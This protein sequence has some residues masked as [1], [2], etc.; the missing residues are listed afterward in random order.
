MASKRLQTLPHPRPRPLACVRAHVL[1]VLPEAC[2]G[3]DDAGVDAAGRR[4][5]EAQGTQ[6]LNGAARG[7]PLGAGSCTWAACVF[8]LG[9]P[10]ARPGQ[11]FPP[12]AGDEAQLLL[13]PHLQVKQAE[14]KVAGLSGSGCAGA[15][16][17]RLAQT[18]QQQKAAAAAASTTAPCLDLGQVFG[19][20]LGHS[21]TA[22]HSRRSREGRGRQGRCGSVAA[23]HMP[24][25]SALWATAPCCRAAEL[26]HLAPPPPCPPAAAPPRGRTPSRSPG[27]NQGGQHPPAALWRQAGRL[28][29]LHPRAPA[30]QPLG[31]L[32]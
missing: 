12:G 5:R 25:P 16:I 20:V 29:P 32:Q 31:I 15:A 11:C 7:M 22:Q 3:G 13:H 24:A 1:A 9:R 27:G 6:A 23:A 18:R 14:K 8:W 17:P 30:T 21:F 26:P 10:P 4:G 28:V 2:A 19:H